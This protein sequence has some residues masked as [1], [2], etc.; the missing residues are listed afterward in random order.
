[1]NRIEFPSEPT[2][3]PVPPPAPKADKLTKASLVFVSAGT[4]A[5]TRDKVPATGNI[6][7]AL[8][9]QQFSLLPA[10]TRL[11]ARL[12]TPVSTAVKAPVVAAI[13]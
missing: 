10:G 9:E 3:A 12:Q 8:I 1:L 13:E 11:A 4:G 2:A 5:G 7:P 6:Q